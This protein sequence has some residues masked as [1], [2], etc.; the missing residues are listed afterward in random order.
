MRIV[1]S[2]D[3]ARPVASGRRGAEDSQAAFDLRM[4]FFAA[5]APHSLGAWRKYIARPGQTQG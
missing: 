4:G 3:S 5:M 1:R 2:R